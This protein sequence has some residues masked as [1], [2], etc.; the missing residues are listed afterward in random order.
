M[1]IE[2]ATGGIPCFCHNI[3][4][5]VSCHRTGPCFVGARTT[6]RSNGFDWRVRRLH[7][8]Q[9]PVAETSEY[10]LKIMSPSK[11]AWRNANW[12]VKYLTICGLLP[13]DALGNLASSWT[14]LPYLIC[15]CTLLGE[16][17]S[18]SV[19]RNCIMLKIT[20]TWKSSADRRRRWI[21]RDIVQVCL[22]FSSGSPQVMA[23]RW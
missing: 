19:C 5:V 17:A 8:L 21:V 13:L 9:E 15:S 1:H 18:Q 16:H 7:V 20:F 23:R 3:L 12:S 6:S 10:Y 4:P 2:R 22:T 11:Q 14:T